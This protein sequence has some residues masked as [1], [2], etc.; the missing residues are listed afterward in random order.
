MVIRQAHPGP[1]VPAYGSFEQKWRDAERYKREDNIAWSVLVDDLQGT[2]HQVYGTGADPTYLIGTDGRVSYYNIITGGSSL[3]EAIEALLEQQGRGIVKGGIDRVP[4]ML[5]PLIFG[6]PALRR[7]LWQSVA[8]LM[9]AAPGS[10]LVL[11]LGHGLRPVL[12]PLAA[13][14]KPLPRPV[15]IVLLAVLVLPLL[16]LLQQVRRRREMPVRKQTV[17]HSG[18]TPPP[19]PIP[20]EAQQEVEGERTLQTPSDGAGDYFHR[21]YRV[22]IANAKLTPE[23]LMADMQA[24]LNGF[25]PIAMAQFEKTKGEKHEM[26]VGDE[27]FIHIAGPWDGPVRVIGVSP[28][29]FCFATL[30]GHM[31]AGEI[32]FEATSLPDQ[33]NALRFQI[34][35]W[36]RSRDV[37]VDLAYDKV[38]VAKAAQESMWVHFCERAVEVT[39]GELIGEID[40]WTEKTPYKGEE[41]PRE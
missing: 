13:R 41:I 3:N 6:W 35:S 27:Y 34:Q 11:W 33:P 22:D 5:A 15:K 29:S 39:E 31:E 2:T 25:S 17:E 21:R 24:N 30:E 28:T 40:V 20:R 38:G 1:S 4:H 10:P 12:G 7:G 8:D 32:V 23:A 18:T 19:Q 36:A 16:L 14:I 26:V 37:V 9:V